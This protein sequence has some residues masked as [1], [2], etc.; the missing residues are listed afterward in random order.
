[1]AA[2]C[3][4]TWS[5]T[6]AVHYG[7]QGGHFPHVLVFLDGSRSLS[8]GKLCKIYVKNPLN[9]VK[10]AQNVHKSA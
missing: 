6:V 9:L 1:M 3:W 4:S 2:G 5:L 7:N 8:Q 10:K